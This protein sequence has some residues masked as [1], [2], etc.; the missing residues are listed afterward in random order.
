LRHLVQARLLLAPTIAFAPELD[1][2]A[3]P[4]DGYAI[5]L[6]PLLVRDVGGQTREFQLAAEKFELRV[7]DID[8]LAVG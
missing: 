5:V 7:G 1:G 6:A 2:L 3:D 4:V 8:L